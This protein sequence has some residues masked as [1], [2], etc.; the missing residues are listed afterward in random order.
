[1]RV[2]DTVSSGHNGGIADIKEMVLSDLLQQK[3]A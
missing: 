1:M 3:S 2:A